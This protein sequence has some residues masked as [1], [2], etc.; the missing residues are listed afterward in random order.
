MNWLYILA[1]IIR[2][3]CVTKPFCFRRETG[4]QPVIVVDG[5][6]CIRYLY[7]ALEWVLGGQL[8]E[9]AHKLQSFV[10]CFE[11]LGAKLIFFFDG[12][13]VGEKRRVWI[14]RRLNSLQKVYTLLDSLP[15]QKNLSCVDQSL[16]QLPPG[17]ATR[18]AFKE[19]CHCEVIIIY[20]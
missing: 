15:R 16:F 20:G 14:Q 1:F 7:G 8:K 17:L 6:S 10:K 5:S 3:N 4:R 11:S 9:F 13:T 12:A 19:L 2:G 18:Y